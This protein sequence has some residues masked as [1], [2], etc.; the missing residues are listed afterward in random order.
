MGRF[1]HLQADGPYRQKVLAFFQHLYYLQTHSAE[2]Q[3]G[4]LRAGSNIVHNDEV[5]TSRGK[6]CS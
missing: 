2:Y 4:S 3:E 5:A 6:G 1:P